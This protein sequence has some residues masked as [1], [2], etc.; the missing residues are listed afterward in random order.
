MN[1]IKLPYNITRSYFYRFVLNAHDKIIL[2]TLFSLILCDKKYYNNGLLVVNAKCKT[3]ALA[4]GESYRTTKRSLAKLSKLG[5]IVRLNRARYSSKY[6]L[7]FKT[8]DNERIYLINYH[9]KEYDKWIMR[10]IDNQ[11]EINSTKSPELDC[12]NFILDIHLMKF[13]QTNIEQP[14]ILLNHK[15]KNDCTL[16]ELLVGKTI[17][18]KKPLQRVPAFHSVREKL[19]NHPSMS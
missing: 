11:L 13:I 17:A 6:F 12:S 19:V 14:N 9:I 15:I 4:A 16:Y 2:Q 18:K 7:G 1:Y 8:I 10:I 3:I 5:I